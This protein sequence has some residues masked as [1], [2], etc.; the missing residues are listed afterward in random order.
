MWALSANRLLMEI[1]VISLPTANRFN[2]R[3]YIWLSSANDSGIRLSKIFRKWISGLRSESFRN[4]G[5]EPSAIKRKRKRLSF[6]ENLLLCRLKSRKNFFHRQIL[7]ACD[8]G[9]SVLKR[10]IDFTLNQ[11]QRVADKL[12]IHAH[13]IFVDPLGRQHFDSVGNFG[14]WCQAGFAAI[15]IGI[16]P[17]QR[18]HHIALSGDRSFNRCLTCHKSLIAIGFRHQMSSRAL[19]VTELRR[20]RSD[21]EAAFDQFGQ[22]FARSTQSGVSEGIGCRRGE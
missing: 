13:A 10:H 17:N 2:R 8:R 5:T 14:K 11:R 18:Y 9:Q 21:I 19:N 4:F 3:V 20:P 7:E 12:M 22:I 1:R 6:E 15:M 16:S